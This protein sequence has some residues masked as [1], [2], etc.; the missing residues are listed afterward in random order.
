MYY[1]RHCLR[2]QNKIQEL[3]EKS[4]QGQAPQ[5]QAPQGQAP[6]GFLQDGCQPVRF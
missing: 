5:G 3:E 1:R 4:P 6:Q 2:E